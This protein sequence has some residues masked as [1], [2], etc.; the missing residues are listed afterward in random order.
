[1][2]E[3]IIN[4]FF[5]VNGKYFDSTVFP[6]VRQM[7]VNA[8]ESLASTLVSL[9]FKEPTTLLLLSIFLGGYGVDRFILGDVGMGLLKLFTGGLCGVLWII[10]IINIQQKTKEYNLNTLRTALQINTM[11]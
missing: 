4:N 2:T 8:D 7:L 6:Q 3:L 10:D 5:L 11:H 1:M 9:D